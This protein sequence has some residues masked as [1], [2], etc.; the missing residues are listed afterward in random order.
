MKY[1]IYVQIVSVFAPLV[2]LATVWFY[3]TFDLSTKTRVAL[4][5][6]VTIGLLLIALLPVM[7][8]GLFHQIIR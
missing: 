6:A 3:E 5:L 7:F 1:E 8:P 2:A 4:I